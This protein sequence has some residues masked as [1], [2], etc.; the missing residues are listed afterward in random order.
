MI[1]NFRATMLMLAALLVCCFFSSCSGLRYDCARDS[2]GREVCSYETTGTLS[3]SKLKGKVICDVH[4]QGN[5]PGIAVEWPPHAVAYSQVDTQKIYRLQYLAS[6]TGGN[7]EAP[8][9]DAEVLHRI[10]DGDRI[11]YDASIC[12]L[13]RITMTW[14]EEEQVNGGSY[15]KSYFYDGR[16]RLFPHDGKAYLLCGSGLQHMK[17]KCPTCYQGSEQW[18]KRHRI[19]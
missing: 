2:S 1:I 6:R 12:Y 11:L 7:E 16:P 3:F 5:L 17:W 14:Q 9:W 8:R 19:E 18:K 10:I 15:Y 13:H 4:P